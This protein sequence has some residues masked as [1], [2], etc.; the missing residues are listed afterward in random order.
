MMYR[1]AALFCL[2]VLPLLAKAGGGN[3]TLEFIENR[4]QWDAPFRYK[5][6]TGRGD[7]FLQERGFT[8][9]VGDPAND[10]LRDALKHGHVKTATMRFHAYRTEFVGATPHPVLA[11]QKPQKWYYNYFLG[12]DSSHWKSGIHPCMAVDYK[13]L[14]PG[15]AMHVGSEGGSLKYELQVARGADPSVVKLR[16]EGTDGLSIKGG[17]LQVKTS[18]GTVEEAEPLAYQWTADGRKTVP[19]YYKVSGNTLSYEMPDGWDKSLPL[20]IDPTVVFSTFTGSSAD[21]WGFTA[22][23]DAGGNFYSGGIVSNNNGSSGTG[24][25]PVST[26]AFQTT[27]GGGGTPFSAVPG[28]MAFIKFDPTGATKI[29][30]SY[31]GGSANDQPHSMVVDTNNNLVVA[32]RSFSS[33]FPVTTGCYDNTANGQ[34]DIVITKFN[35]TGTALLGSTYLGGSGEDGVNIF[36]DENMIGSLKFN[37][38]DDARSEVILDRAGNVYVA[39]ASSSTDFPMANATQTAK[40]GAQDAVIVKLSPNLT[41]LLWSTYLGGTSQDAA[42]VLALDTGQTQLYVAGGTASTNF[43]MPAGGG[44]ING[45]YQG[46]TADGYIVR[47]GNGGT[48]PYQKGTFIGKASYDQCFGVQVDLENNV[49]AMGQTLGGT[50]P[51]STGVYSNSNSSQFVIKVNPDLSSTIYSTVFGSGN[52][53]NP[54]ISP[55]AFLVDT[56]QNVYIS[57][58][59][60]NLG[61]ANPNNVGTTGMPTTAGLQLPLKSTTDGQDF[62]FFALSKNATAQLFGAFFGGAG[63]G[64]HVDGGTSRFDRNG[65]IY[66]AVCAGCGGSS[67]FPTTTGS[68]SPTNGSQNC[69]LGS[70]KIAFNLGA[71]DATAQANPSAKGCP[72]LTVNFGNTSTN[73]TSYTWDFGDNTSGSTSATPTHTYTTKGIYT[74]RLIAE[75]PNA[76]KTRD[77]VF[78]TI[79]VDTNRIK[80]GFTPQILDSCGPYRVQFNNTS[81]LS[82]TPGNTSYLWIYGDGT[83][84][85]GVNPGIHNYPDTGIYNA[86]LVMTDPTACNSPDTFRRTIN[87]NGR[88]VRAGFNAPDSVCLSSTGNVFVSTSQ[89]AAS[90]LWRFGDNTPTETTNS[91]QHFYKN[92]GTYTVTLVATNPATCNKVDS[93]QRTV[94]VKSL[95]KAAF[96]YDPIIPI[97]N[98]PI[99]FMNR[100]VNAVSYRWAFGDAT[101]STDKDP[102]HMYKRT[103]AYTVC[104]TATS[105]DGCQ[106]TACKTV[107][108]DIHTACDVPTGFSPNGDGENDI[109]YVRGAA[110]EELDF[111]VFN[112]WGQ[113]VFQTDDKERGWDGT[114]NGKPQE[115]EAYAFV[116]TA[117]FIDGSSV[118][119]TGNVTLLR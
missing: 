13:Q 51:V 47:Y 21:N 24:S 95:P 103:G 56:C 96:D 62:Y 101:G 67:A 100:S 118:K 77:T 28:D 45:S 98:T 119:K 69:N 68:F 97:S 114:F 49:Y 57:G 112:R 34:H 46:G 8:V 4:G 85:T 71:V 19:C 73:A 31:L 1:Y 82:A 53:I 38:G 23:Y 33:N 35:S 109:L 7:V 26:G 92:A 83:T 11:G 61:N 25:F 93:V 2:S 113:L 64:E 110:I 16:Y 89:N 60:G 48:Y 81:Q 107:E 9:L 27:Y 74:A 88:R 87:L 115:V 84:S 90:L 111:K 30:A 76:C 79:I 42:Y 20:V 78:L 94:K 5:A 99:S 70:V 66:Q 105:S 55:V 39:S 75:N 50:F 6:A 44:G 117:T 36:A 41:S 116:L 58:W 40:A 86:L 12:S 22:T 54:N 37:Y 91:P 15:I 80:A 29:W 104:L 10:A 63:L 3:T 65:V 43:P 59:G 102:T 17:R 32:G 18:V 108:A 72:P 14:Y 52:S 106:D